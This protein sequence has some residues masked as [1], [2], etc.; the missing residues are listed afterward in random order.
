MTQT[1]HGGECLH[2]DALERETRRKNGRESRLEQHAA[3]SAVNVSHSV[4]K[5]IGLY[6]ITG[7]NRSPI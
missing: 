3:G 1:L 6:A 5:H 7:L 2:E 4:Q